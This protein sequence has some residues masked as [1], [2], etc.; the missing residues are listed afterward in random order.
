MSFIYIYK[1]QDEGQTDKIK[2]TS[3]E[4][5]WI[6]ASLLTDQM[7]D[8]QFDIDSVKTIQEDYQGDRRIILIA[9]CTQ[10]K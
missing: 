10:I 8:S 1:G 3:K 5:E 2:E 4:T 7:K 9:Y 6:I